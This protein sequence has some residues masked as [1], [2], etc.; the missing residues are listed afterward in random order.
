MGRSRPFCHQIK[1]VIIGVASNLNIDEVVSLAVDIKILLSQQCLPT[2]PGIL[3][4]WQNR[5]LVTSNSSF[6][7][8][9]SIPKKASDGPTCGGLVDADL[10]SNCFEMH[11]W[12]KNRM[13]SGGV[14][15]R[16]TVLR[17]GPTQTAV[18]Q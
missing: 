14:A 12:H 9:A 1:D 8:E 4:V 10:V 13:L 15:A 11:H 18:L 5:C 17:C 7:G 2:I 3:E 6:S 16:V